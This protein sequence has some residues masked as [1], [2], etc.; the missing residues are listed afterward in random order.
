MQSQ[1]P[2]D[3]SPETRSGSEVHLDEWVGPDIAD[4]NKLVRAGNILEWMDVVGVL[5]ATRLCRMPVVTASVDGMDLRDPIQVG[6]HVAMTGAIACTT[7]RSIGVSVEVRHGARRDHESKVMHGYMTFVALDTHGKAKRV[8]QFAPGTPVE[9]ERFREG[10]IRQEFRRRMA[11]GQEVA[12]NEAFSR[13]IAAVSEKER[14]FMVGE[15]LKILPRNFRLPWERPDESK[16][17]ARHYSYVHKIEPV[18]SAKLN[19]HRTLYGG[20]LM[21]WIETAANLSARAYL[22]GRPVRLRGL[23]GLTFIKPVHENLFVHIRSVIVHTS[24]TNLTALV[25]VRAEDPV[26]S[27][28]TETLRA[29]L[30][31]EPIGVAGASRSIPRLE[32]LGDEE[33]ALSREVELRLELQRNL[34]GEARA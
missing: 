5:A 9:L 18:R 25:N 1:A 13:A 32:C 16:P 28:S 31:F 27:T 30:T 26:G 8:P 22:D 19:F 17:R 10:R 14:P 34:H 2:A 7:P 3:M 24:Q 15:L 12:G 6:E 29:F 4:E 21:R 20:T 11:S 23:H 33:R